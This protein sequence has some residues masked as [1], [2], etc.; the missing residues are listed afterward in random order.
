MK[1]QQYKD[2]LDEVVAINNQTQDIGVDYQ[3]FET[4]CDSD[5]YQSVTPNFEG[6]L[7][8]DAIH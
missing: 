4:I 1:Q 8:L 3:H 6:N 5:G 7:N 2:L